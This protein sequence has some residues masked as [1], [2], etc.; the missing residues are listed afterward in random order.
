MSNFDFTKT[1]LN[2]NKQYIDAVIDRVAANA[3]NK[4]HTH[5][6]NNLE[7]KPFGE[8]VSYTIYADGEVSTD[9]ELT[10]GHGVFSGYLDDIFAI[11][12]DNVYNVT[13]DGVL[14]ENV[15]CKSGDASLSNNNPTLGSSYEE[16]KNN[17]T[18]EYPF[19]IC[20]D[21]YYKTYI[22]YTKENAVHTIKIEKSALT[23]KTIDPKYLPEHLQFGETYFEEGDILQEFD[24]IQSLS[25]GLDKMLIE[26]NT[27]KVICDGIEYEC[28]ARNDGYNDIYIGNQS[29]SDGWGFPEIIESDEPFFIY[30]YSEGDY[31]DSIIYFVDE[32]EHSI[33][34]IKGKAKPLDPKYLPEHTHSWNDL[35][36]RPFGNI[37]GE[38]LHIPETTAKFVSNAGAYHPNIAPE[39]E[40]SQ[41]LV[42]GETYTVV[43]DGVKYENLV[44]T[45]AGI[46]NLV[47]LGSLGGSFSDY[48]FFLTVDEVMGW[49]EIDVWANTGGNHTFTIY[50]IGE[51]IKTLDQKYLPEEIARTEY[52]D[53]NFALKSEIENI[54]Q[55]QM[56]TWGADD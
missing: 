5:S 9:S 1:L 33:T 29:V 6:W 37:R 46:N 36:D 7:D 18:T 50:R 14:Y 27:Y 43:W 39:V 55:I 51:E 53:V 25:V 38:V 3:A 4:E 17:D 10:E 26:G 21:T 54:P 34:I 28:I 42:E 30:T 11:E 8:E 16:L 19:Q 41:I 13:I 40:L 35:E 31:I 15:F 24:S 23:S 45:R 22:V 44:G 48:P 20:F 52:V 2:G 49:A 32:L 12:V 47:T 56:I